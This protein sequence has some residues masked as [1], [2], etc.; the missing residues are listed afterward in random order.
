MNMNES[1]DQQAMNTMERYGML[2]PGARVIV[3]LSGGADSMALLFFLSSLRTDRG[4]ALEAA[5]VNHLLRG[6]ESD[7]DEQFVRSV[8]ERLSIPLH[9][10]RTDVRALA[11]EEGI[12]LEECGRRV[13]YAFFA[14]LGGDALIATAHTLSDSMET[15]YYHLAR[16][17][18]LR[19]ICGIPPVRGHTVRPLIECTRSQVEEYCAAHSISYRTDASNS[20]REYTRN[21]IRLDW[22]PLIRQLNPSAEDAARRFLA[23]VR[24]DEAYLD[25]LAQEAVCRAEREKGYDAAQLA[26]LDAPIRH[27]ALYCLLYRHGGVMPERK[28]IIKAEELLKHGGRASLNGGTDT[29]VSG[30]ILTFPV[31]EDPFVPFCIPLREGVHPIPGGTAEIV[32]GDFGHKKFKNEGLDICIDCDKIRRKAVIRSRLP[33]DMLKM[34]GRCRKKLKKLFNEF[35][36]PLSVRRSCVILS[37]E[38]GVLWAEGLGPDERACVGPN[39]DRFYQ[40][41][42]WRKI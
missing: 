34:P 42:I 28:H 26:G 18:G 27:R 41:R 13:R 39:T 38:C 24:E 22:M 4:W 30:G 37:D 8:C 14:S 32:P 12:G 6:T 29:V 35:H 19:G 15:L 10:Q 31:P 2:A 17:S 40:I 11:E 1:L 16:G 33:G 3:A 5:H 36:A 20:S 21:R 25:R 23:D 7:G 9:V